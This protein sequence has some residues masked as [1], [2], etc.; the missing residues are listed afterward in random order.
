[1]GSMGLKKDGGAAPGGCESNGAVVEGGKRGCGI[2]DEKE[3]GDAV[4]AVGDGL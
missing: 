2:P 4:V 1:M 3:G